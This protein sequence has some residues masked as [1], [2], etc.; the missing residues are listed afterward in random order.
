M[1]ELLQDESTAAREEYYA[2]AVR[3][4]HMH[5]F[6]Y[7]DRLGPPNPSQPCAQLLK[8]TANMWYCKNNYPMEIVCEELQP[9]GRSGCASL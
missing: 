1:L 7:P 3:T 4:E 5:N 2:R 9:I 8:G 6:H